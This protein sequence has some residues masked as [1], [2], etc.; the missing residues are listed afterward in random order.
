MNDLRSKW[1]NENRLGEINATSQFLTYLPSVS[2][3]Y[4]TCQEAVLSN[5]ILLELFDF[6]HVTPDEYAKGMQQHILNA[7]KAA[8]VPDA[9]EQTDT[10]T[11]KVAK[12]HKTL[13]LPLVLRVNAY[14]TAKFLLLRGILNEQNAVQLALTYTNFLEKHAK[15]CMKTGNTEWRF[16]ALME[17]F[18]D[19]VSSLNLDYNGWLGCSPIWPA[20]FLKKYGPMIPLAHKVHQ[21]VSFSRCNGVSTYTCGL[22]SLQMRQ[23]CLFNSHSTRSAL[24]R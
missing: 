4:L 7:M 9:L 22:A 16:Q 15:Q 11:N 10:S 23:F 14:T 20:S 24:H 8:Q 5:E 2:I 17:G 13:N 3:F 21:T 18:Y 6:S 12:Y 19:F 1:T